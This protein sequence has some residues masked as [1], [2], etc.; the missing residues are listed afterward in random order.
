MIS[1]YINTTAILILAVLAAL[2]I[3]SCGEDEPQLPAFDR[4]QFLA[5]QADEEILPRI[6]SFMTAVDACKSAIAQMTAS[7]TA[8]SVTEARAKF[9]TA[10]L[11]WQRVN[12]LNFG[13]GAKK[14]L[15][16]SLA[17]ELGLFP[18]DTEE[19]ENRI[20]NA[21][22]T[23]DDHRRDTRGLLGIDYILHRHADPLA[24]ADAMDSNTANYLMAV[25]NKVS[26]QASDFD[27]AWK[28]YRNEFVTNNGTDV[29][30]STTQY[31]NDWLRSYELL[32]NLKITEP[33]GLKAGQTSPEPHLVE[34][35]NSGN[36]LEYAKAHFNSLVDVFENDSN[37]DSVSW[38]DYLLSLQAGAGLVDRIESQINK[39]NQ[40]FDA[41]P[42]N[43]TL[44]ELVGQE[45]QQVLNLQK[46]LQALVP[47]I[48][49]EMSSLMGIAITFSTTDGD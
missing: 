39:I 47:L 40:A 21:S 27:T 38:K 43:A 42:T 14:G 26:Q 28:T 1:K 33:L 35:V 48:K 46:E 41:V 18:L 37:Q 17:E 4:D 8:A 22:A 32:K 23:V 5:L 19:I 7:P 2:M 9:K 3:H 13:P 31:Y 16:L 12:F 25:I 11:A 15:K 29:K 49:S 36:S 44:K 30:S 20:A 10:Y 24:L 45:N 6:A 34:C